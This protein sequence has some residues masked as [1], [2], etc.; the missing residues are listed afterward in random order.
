MS[1]PEA[2]PDW[3]SWLIQLRAAGVPNKVLAGLVMAD[4]EDRWDQQQRELQRKFDN[5]DVD[6]DVLAAADADH[7]SALDAEM[8]QALGEQGFR[9]WDRERTLRDFDFSGVNLSTSERDGLYQ[10]RKDL[11][12]KRKEFED[13]SRRGEIDEA[14]LNAKLAAAQ[15]DYQQQMKTLLGDARYTALTTTPDPG[16]GDLKRQ[17]RGLNVGDDQMTALMQAQQQWSHQRSQINDDAPGYETQMQALDKARDDAFQKILGPDGYAAYQKQQDASYLTLKH[18][19]NAWQLAPGDIDYLYGAIHNYNQNVQDYR[20]RA[21]AM[22][23]QGQVVDWD[24]V[25]K[26]IDSFSQQTEQTLSFYLGA[27]RFS[28]IKQNDVFS[29]SVQN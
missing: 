15:A 25:Q 24:S 1:A 14:E 10:L 12:T 22:E 3:H 17:V 13:A 7:A 29:F 2:N 6:P 11:S 5:G 19:A 4:F 28:K 20:D 8:R 9:D 18:Y 23:A 16:I 21:R 26:N 27:D